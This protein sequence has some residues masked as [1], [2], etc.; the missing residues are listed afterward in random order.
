MC[1]VYERTG[2]RAY[3]SPYAG[4][5]GAILT[6]QLRGIAKHPVDEQTASLPYASSL[7][8]ACFEVCPVRIDIPEIL[9]HL[10]AKVVD[11][12]GWRASHLSQEAVLLGGLGS[13]FAS[14]GRLD[15]LERVSG[16]AARPL[17]RGG[18]IGRLRLPGMLGAW[19]GGRDLPAPA[20]PSFRR[21]WK[22]R[23]P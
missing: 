3:G 1:P 16:V 13:T 17:S 6:P 15:T 10:R 5:I 12:H 7:C 14:S 4:P 22:G 23:T 11:Q 2:G 18:R 20:R 9:V 19:F 21:W 8:G